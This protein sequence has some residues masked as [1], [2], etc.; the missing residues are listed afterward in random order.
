MAL[1]Y[2]GGARITGLSTDTKPTL[3]PA[4]YEFIET[5]TARKLFWNG[6]TWSQRA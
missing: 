4:G 5:D 6:S 1:A 3:L 2:W